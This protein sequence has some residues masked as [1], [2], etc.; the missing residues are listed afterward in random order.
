ML[1]DEFYEKLIVPHLHRQQQELEVYAEVAMI[2]TPI[3]LPVIIIEEP[4]QP[5]L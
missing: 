1:Q 3:P 2:L 4:V 5:N